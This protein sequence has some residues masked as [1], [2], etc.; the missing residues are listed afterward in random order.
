MFPATAIV[1]SVVATAAENVVIVR[2][3]Q[4]AEIAKAF[5][6]SSVTSTILHS[7]GFE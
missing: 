1:V 7:S 6:A 4:I 5:A 2:V 3:K